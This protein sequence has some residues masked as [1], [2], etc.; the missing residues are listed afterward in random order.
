MV[1]NQQENCRMGILKSKF[2]SKEAEK[3]SIIAQSKKRFALYFGDNSEPSELEILKANLLYIYNK[4]GRAKTKDLPTNKAANA[5][6]RNIL[7]NRPCTAADIYTLFSTDKVARKYLNLFESVCSPELQKGI[8]TY[9]LDRRLKKA[10]PHKKAAINALKNNQTLIPEHIKALTT[11]ATGKLLAYYD[12]DFTSQP[13]SYGAKISELYS[14]RKINE[15]TEKH[16]LD[17]E[18]EAAKNF[19]ILRR[20]TLAALSVYSHKKM[21][22][23]WGKI[24]QC[25]VSFFAKSKPNTLSSRK[26]HA[27]NFCA[28][29]LRGKEPAF[30][31]SLLSAE[32][33]HSS[34]CKQSYGFIVAL[35]TGKLGKIMK[36]ILP[37]FIKNFKDDE[38][39][40]YNK[41]VKNFNEYESAMGCS[42][43]FTRY[44][45]RTR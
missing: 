2:N 8:F 30:P 12:F 19:D 20:S 42:D 9:E 15:A 37:S 11:G 7:T 45:C 10:G 17:S 14:Y 23:T 18:A 36:D 33:Q 3:A 4:N 22:N 31:P 29:L 34:E 40:N 16:F 1:F 13:S 21:S 27:V 38:Q 32:C 43:S 5:I 28:S 39:A 24:K 6:L 35:R 25:N 26:Q 41:H 44:D